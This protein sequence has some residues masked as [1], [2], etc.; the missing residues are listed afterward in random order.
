MIHM[1]SKKPSIEIANSISELKLLNDTMGGMMMMYEDMTVR[2]ALLYSFADVFINV[3]GLDKENLISTSVKENIA[4]KRH[5]LMWY[6][7]K[8][9]FTA[10]E[11]AVYFNRTQYSVTYACKKQEE[12]YQVWKEEHDEQCDKEEAVP[13]TITKESVLAATVRR[14]GMGDS[15]CRESLDEDV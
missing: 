13:E 6:F 11:I 5:E 15:I 7:R 4:N 10:R 9:G 1:R 3:R 2:G 8:M 12:I 14:A